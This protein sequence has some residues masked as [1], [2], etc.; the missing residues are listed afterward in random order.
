MIAPN[1]AYQYGP[2]PAFIARPSLRIP[3]SPTRGPLAAQAQVIETNKVSPQPKLTD[4]ED[5]GG[6]EENVRYAA[7]T[8]ATAHDCL[9]QA[10]YYERDSHAIQE[11]PFSHQSA[12]QDRDMNDRR[13]ISKRR[14]SRAKSA[15]TSEKEQRG[16]TRKAL[17][18]RPY[19]AETQRRVRFSFWRFGPLVRLLCETASA[20]SNLFVHISRAVVGFSEVLRNS[21]GKRGLHLIGPPSGKGNPVWKFHTGWG[22]WRTS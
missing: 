11:P 6:D 7:Y 18:R 20:L 16:A 5:D 10:Y 14:N 15:R 4:E 13:L 8:P 9:P 12:T 3:A 21:G 22:I 1:L 2:S 17:S 19:R